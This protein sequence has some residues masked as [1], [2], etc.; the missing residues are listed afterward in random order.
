MVDFCCVHNSTN[1]GACRGNL[2]TKLF[3][4]ALQHFFTTARNPPPRGVG[5]D[6]VVATGYMATV[7]RANYNRLQLFPGGLTLDF[8]T[9]IIL[10]MDCLFIALF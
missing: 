8:E 1:Q 9:I 5:G 3:S 7:H 6:V 10:I 4:S 2:W